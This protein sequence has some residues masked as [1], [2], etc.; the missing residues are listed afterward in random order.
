MQ[1]FSTLKWT[2]FRPLWRII[3]SVAIPDV[4][5][6]PG[7]K[8]DPLAMP[9]LYAKPWCLTLLAS[10]PPAGGGGWDLKHEVIDIDIHASGSGYITCGDIQPDRVTGGVRW[11]T[12]VVTGM[13]RLG[14]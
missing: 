3:P 14:C 11:S 2:V 1:T 8:Q 9:C 5:Y 13:F 4:G 7:G 6:T 12:C 10:A